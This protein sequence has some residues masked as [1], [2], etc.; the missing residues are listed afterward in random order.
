MIREIFLQQNAYDPVDTYCPMPRQFMMLK[1]IK[2]FSD[3]AQKALVAGA[4]VDKIIA[5]PARQRFIRSKYEETI[6][7]ELVGIDKDFDEQFK[8][9][10]A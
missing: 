2:K 7:D 3:L 8:E 1:L 4:T 5:I 9:L 10:G 6:D